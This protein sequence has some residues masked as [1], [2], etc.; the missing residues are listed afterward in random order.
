[1]G[2]KVPF[3]VS[4][5]TNVPSTKNHVILTSFW[6]S[7]TFWPNIYDIITIY[8]IGY[9]YIVTPKAEELLAWFPPTHVQEEV[10]L[11]TNL[12]SLGSCSIS[13]HRVTISQCHLPRFYFP[14]Y[15]HFVVGKEET[16]LPRNLF[17]TTHFTYFLPRPG[18]SAH[19]P[20]QTYLDL[21]VYKVSFW[22]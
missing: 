5:V 21:K 15:L 7:Y 19:I 6:F 13:N 2:G 8:D 12:L 1:M 22:T 16:A 4:Y 18:S 17:T 3:Q 14:P 10:V 11:Y 20:W 9:I